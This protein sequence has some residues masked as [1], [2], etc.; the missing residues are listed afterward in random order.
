MLIVRQFLCQLNEMRAFETYS[1]TA[2]SGPPKQVSPTSGT[3]VGME[4]T[5]FVEDG[6]C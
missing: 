6:M 4:G 2:S 5:R 3:T 1:I